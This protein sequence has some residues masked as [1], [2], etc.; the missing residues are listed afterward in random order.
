VPGTQFRS[1]WIT[2]EHFLN[3]CQDY[4]AAMQVGVLDTDRQREIAI[5]C[6]I[7]ISSWAKAG[8]LALI[9]EAMGHQYER[10]ED[11]L[12]IGLHQY[13]ESRGI[14]PVFDERTDRRLLPFTEHIFAD[15][16]L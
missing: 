7:F 9:E 14:A 12:P 13:S 11:A 10:A 5:K 16:G 6:S 4:V 15:R 3:I 2:A 8:L 1:R